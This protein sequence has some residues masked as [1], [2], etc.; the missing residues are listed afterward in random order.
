MTAQRL[1][2]SSSD[3]RLA[4]LTGRKVFASDFRPKDLVDDLGWPDAC[5][6]AL[7]VRAAGVNRKF[8]GLELDRLAPDIRPF[9]VVTA[10]TLVDAGFNNKTESQHFHLCPLNSRPQY[11][12]Q[13]LAIL[14][15]QDFASFR[16]AAQ[17]I[18]EDRGVARYGPLE[19]VPDDELI[20]AILQKWRQLEA[21]QGYRTAH[22]QLVEEPGNRL[23]AW[24]SGRLSRSNGKFQRKDQLSPRDDELFASIGHEIPTSPRFVATTTFTQQIDPAFMEPET[25]LAYLSNGELTMLLGTQSVHSDAVEVQK[26]VAA[27]GNVGGARVGKVNLISLDP[28]G[29][30]GGKDKSP[31]AVQLAFAAAFADRPVRLAY[32]RFEQFQAGLKRH[33]SAVHSTLSAREDGILDQALIHL[34]LEG[35]VEPNLGNA[36]LDLGALHAT[37]MYRWRRAACHGLLSKRACPIVGSMRG[38]G[39]PQ[40]AFNIETAIDKLAILRLEV[41]PIEFRRRNALAW[42]SD[43]TKAHTDL[44]GT[45]LRFHVATAELC[46]RALNAPLWIERNHRRE[47]AHQSGK[48][49]GVGFAACMQAYGTSQ[50]SVYCG[51]QLEEDGTIA[52]FSQTVDM[53]QGAR[54]SMA[55]A[56]AAMTKAG[57]AVWF[58]RREPFESFAKIL[59]MQSLKSSTGHGA[60]SASKTA[61]FHIHVMKEA[62]RALLALRVCPFIAKKLGVSLAV[63]EVGEALSSGHIQTGAG[64]AL[65]WHRLASAM[66]ADNEDRFCIAHGYFANGW[67]KAVFK[68]NGARHSAFLDGLAFGGDVGKVPNLVSLDGPIVDPL[69]VGPGGAAATRSGYAGGAHLVEVELD[70][71]NR[72]IQVLAAVCFLDAG[73]PVFEPALLGQVEGGFQMGLAHSLFEELPKESGVDRY[74]NFDRYRLP[75]ASDLRNISFQCE[76]ISLPP[77]GALNHTQPNIRHKGVGEV[78]MTTVAPALA[79]AIAHA[80]GHKGDNCWPTKLPIRFGDLPI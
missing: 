4:K 9:K 74:V 17:E 24:L 38:F 25:G 62:I 71:L 50:D 53:G 48:L 66:S 64:D 33:A 52:V 20:E 31:F 55:A 3:L 59:S 65:T 14:L 26:A 67:A 22:L 68:A 77:E 49:R 73:D 58:G 45:P 6:H 75:R 34:V 30:F 29:G 61:F 8:L 13:P 47:Q 32:D 37:G 78:T 21:V 51:V 15:F 27:G 72:T 41:D 70:P 63:D 36:V 56:A 12:S 42:S 43:A 2:A 40:V 23:S 44:A 39:I 54:Q 7:L 16:R 80:L 79:N 28:G 18:R 35:G 1:L 19:A 69:R 60:S 5:A 76:L 10:Q 46:E 57:V 11:A